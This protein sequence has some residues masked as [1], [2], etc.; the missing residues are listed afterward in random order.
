MVAG[1]YVFRL[2]V[3]DGRATSSQVSVTYT[4]NSGTPSPTTLSATAAGAASGYVS[5]ASPTQRF[6]S[7]DIRSGK[8]A[9]TEYRGAAQ[10]ILPAQPDDTYLSAVSLDLM[11]KSNSGNTAGDAW[12]VDLL[13]TSV[14]ADWN[15]TATWNSM[16]TITADDTLSP[17]L[18]GTGQV[19]L[20]SLDTWTFD[21]AERDVVIGRLAGSDKLSI[22]T[23]G[24]NFA[25]S[26][27]NW[28]GGNATTVANRPKLSLTFS[29]SIQYDHDPIARAGR[30]AEGVINAQVTLDGASS[31]DYEDGTVTHS[32]TQLGGPTVTLSSSTAASPTFTPTVPGIYRFQDTVS[33]STS[34]TANDEVV[35]RISAQASPAVTSYAYNANG[36]R[37]SQTA[38][39][40]ST[41]YVV[42]SVPTL[43]SV[44]AETTGSATTYFV[45]GHDLLYSVKAD[46]PHFH[47]T[48]ALGSTIAVTGSTGTVEQTMDY[49]VFGQLRSI[50]GTSG[51][52]Y[53][54]TGEENDT[55]GLIYLRARYY[56]PG[57]GRFLS[58]DPYPA[59]AADTQTINRYVYVKN[60]PTNYVDPSGETAILTPWKAYQIKQR[61]LRN[62]KGEGLEGAV[63]HALAA[64]YMASKYGVDQAQMYTDLNEASPLV[65]VGFW[66]V[67]GFS[68]K[69]DDKYIDTMHDIHNNREGILSEL[70]GRPID[71]RGLVIRDGNTLRSPTEQ[72]F[73]SFMEAHKEYN[74]T[75]DPYFP[76]SGGW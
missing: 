15:T 43:A 53:T 32:W 35:V 62:F 9:S 33:D 63:R 44:V 14:D 65:K 52:T 17:V 11:G 6:F 61:F 8:S 10:F 3:S 73:A 47:H 1:T 45:Y 30:D 60:N 40:V 12:S 46:V 48:D 23:Q 20:N 16:G 4:V 24:N 31:F 75:F 59:D 5:S 70:E 71:W 2:T 51:T 22:R 67:A 50:T 34:H 42:N 25:N 49:D 66:K 18:T 56:D 57:T 28:Y 58:R 26:T 13:P 41:S 38:D 39:S 7:N 37:I 54:F 19:V 74:G 27:V 76:S 72:E 36:D 29:P 68:D 64:K 55:S 21:A 69:A